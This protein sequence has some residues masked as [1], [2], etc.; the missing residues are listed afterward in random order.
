MTKTVEDAILFEAI[1][2]KDELDATSINLRPTTYD[3][4]LEEI[5]KL[6]NRVAEEYF[7]GGLSKEVE[8]G[9]EE[10]IKN[11][12]SLKIEFKEISLPRYEIRLILLLHYYAGGSQRESGEV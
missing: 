11:L 5:R 8:N 1:K 2:G 10:A 12:K 6:K 3:L 7:T 4:R 9:I